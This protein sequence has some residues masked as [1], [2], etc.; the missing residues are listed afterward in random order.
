MSQQEQGQ[1]AHSKVADSLAGVHAEVEQL[2]SGTD[3]L[4]YRPLG[5][6]SGSVAL[7]LIGDFNFPDTGWE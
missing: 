3:E 4:P 5:E 1:Q 2:C 6:L 7:V